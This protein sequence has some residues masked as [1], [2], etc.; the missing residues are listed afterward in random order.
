VNYLCKGAIR[1]ACLILVL[2]IT[3]P[4]SATA[5]EIVLDNGDR[6]TGRIVT[7]KDGVLTLETSY[8][9]PI[10]ITFSSVREMTGTEPVAIHLAGGEV[11][12]GT[13]RSVA[14]GQLEVAA[15]PDREAVVVDQKTIVALNPPPKPPVTW[16]GSVTM[17][18]N[19]QD[20][21]TNTMNLSIGAQAIR[22]SEKDRISTN[23]LYNRAAVSNS[24]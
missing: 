1:T 20:G 12:R 22:R 7:I 13:I 5:D 15:G 6:L 16:K 2:T 11:I 14:N 21:N 8:S 4:P 19:L 23:F 24:G 18:G 10:K 17:G 3:A 9:E